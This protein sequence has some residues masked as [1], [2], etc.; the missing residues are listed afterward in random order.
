MFH[1]LLSCCN[2]VKLSKQ[3]YSYSLGYEKKILE[4]PH[5]VHNYSS[6]VY[7]TKVLRL[8]YAKTPG[9]GTT[10]WGTPVKAPDSD[11]GDAPA[12]I[13]I[14]YKT[15]HIPL[16]MLPSSVKFS[17]RQGTIL[18]QQHMED[19]MAKLRRWIALTG[20]QFV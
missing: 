1:I 14:L 17:S 10:P 4:N 8:F 3:H 9:P 15:F 7:H 11:T 5:S 12:D 18:P 6:C 16:V 2:Y 20:N 19:T 13:H